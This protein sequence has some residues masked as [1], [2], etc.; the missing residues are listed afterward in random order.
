[1]SMFRSI[2][3]LAD[4]VFPGGITRSMTSS[5]PCDGF[6]P[7]EEDRAGRRIRLQY[8]R[9]QRAL[10][11]AHVDDGSGLR[12]V[13]GPE[14]GCGLRP[15]QRDHRLAERRERSRVLR[16][17]REEIAPGVAVE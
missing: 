17:K 4:G 14:D 10:P 3:L 5:L 1:M 9:Q 11:A 2:H 16:Q 7:I 12:E 13:V 8:G 6:G 15:R